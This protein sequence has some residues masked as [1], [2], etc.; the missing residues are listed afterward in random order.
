MLGKCIIALCSEDITTTCSTHQLCSGLKSDIKV[1]IHAMQE[2][3]GEHGEEENWGILLV[4]AWNAFNE[5]NQRVML[6]N[7]RHALVAGSQFA[8]NTYHHW[9]KL[10]LCRHK[11]LVMSKEG[12]TQG[13]PLDMILYALAILPII[14]HLKKIWE[15]NGMMSSV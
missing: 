12:I 10:V 6:W 7:V 1:V 13:D 11:D 9:R 2:M 3:W 5:V 8:F 4:D 14:L 15:R